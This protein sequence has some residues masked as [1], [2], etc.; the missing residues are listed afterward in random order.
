MW[1]LLY[2][3]TSLYHHTFV[4]P[5]LLYG[6]FL[7]LSGLPFE[8]LNSIPTSSRLSP[9]RII[10]NLLTSR[11]PNEQYLFLLC[12]DCLDPKLWAGTTPEIPAIL[13]GWEV[14]RIMQSLDS[15]DKLIR[16]KVGFT[17]LSQFPAHPQSVLIDVNN[18]APH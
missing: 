10:R 3:I 15:P 6:S 7:L 1:Y 4:F 18:P 12:L 17:L 13:E 9:V 16:K 11:D 5:A 2:L 14:E 8:T